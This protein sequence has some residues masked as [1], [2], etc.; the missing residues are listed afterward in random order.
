M[1]TRDYRDRFHTV[2]HGLRAELPPL[3]R[4]AVPVICAELGW[5]SMGVVDTMLVGRVSAVAIGAVSIGSTIFY[6]VAIFGMGILL[7]LD[8]LVAR[9]FGAHDLDSAHRAL[10]QGLY[11]SG[12]LAAVLTVLL[13]VAIPGL[14]LLGI[15]DA[16]VRETVPYLRALTWSLLPLLWFSCLRRYLQAMGVVTPVMLTVVTANAV[17][18]VAGWILIYGHFGMPALGAE[19]AGWATCASRVYMFVALAACTIVDATRRRTGLLDVERGIDPKRL[20][21]L[22]RLGLPAAAQTTLEVGV[23]A[24]ATALAGRL[25]PVS[26]A[27]HQIALSVA[28]FIF[29]IPLGISSA[30][31]VRVGQALGR[32][33]PAAATR[34]GWSA[35]FV[36]TVFMVGSGLFLISAP[37]VVMRMFTTR[38]PVI[39]TGTSLLLVAALFQLF[40]GAQVVATGVLRGV[41]DTRTPMISNLV[42]HW[43]LG[44][45]LGAL[46]CFWQGWDVV[47]LWVG[48]SVG[49]V[50]V[51]FVLM[52]VWSRRVAE[53]AGQRRR[54]V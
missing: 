18:A 28:S 40:D 13:W 1:S 17:N 11:V 8:Y 54:T 19:G 7:G 10:F 12:A 43:F 24:A 9:A 26:L 46:L 35:L 30:A 6:A 23:F 21:E 49:L 37:G 16:V 31:A 2:E 20:R 29:M 36:G 4:L 42:A 39:A 3:L 32:G 44:L 22:A 38:I 53:L 47:G 33:D 52:A 41:G 15:R 14:G 25:D 45:P 27:A 50:G 48:L 5:M 34:S 51:A